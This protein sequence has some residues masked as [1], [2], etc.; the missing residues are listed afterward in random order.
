[1]KMTR[2]CETCQHECK[3]EYAGWCKDYQLEITV[4][5]LDYM[6]TFIQ[7]QNII[8]KKHREYWSFVFLNPEGFELLNNYG[9]I[10]V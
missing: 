2:S 5:V 6:A 10:E 8:D 3:S 7:E 9:E 4:K 1:M